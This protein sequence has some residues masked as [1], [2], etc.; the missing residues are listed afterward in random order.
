MT[1]GNLNKYLKK[2]TM[3]T[4]KLTKEEIAFIRNQCMD[5]I[6]ISNT[7]HPERDEEIMQQL[8]SLYNKLAP[9]TIYRL[10]CA[11]LERPITEVGDFYEFCE[12]AKN[13]AD[14]FGD[15]VTL[16]QFIVEDKE[17][18]KLWEAEP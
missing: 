5:Q 10:E 16:K 18:I 14:C 8:E 11:S 17:W 12:K 4:I 1:Q 6:L 2:Y 13:M 7:L 15:T 3:K 9:K